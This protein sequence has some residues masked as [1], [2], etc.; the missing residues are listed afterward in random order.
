MPPPLRAVFFDVDDTLYSTAAFA[1]GARRRA[2]EAMVALGGMRISADDLL[3]ELD[4]VIAE[5]GSNYDAHY[6]RLLRRFPP[7]A[8]GGH[9]RGILVAAGVAAYHNTKVE[10]FRAFPGVLDGLRRLRETTGLVLGVITEGLEVKQA[11]KIVRLGIYPWLD[12]RA[13]FISDSIGISKPNPKL[14]QR[15]CACVGIEPARCLY[16]GDNPR[17][18][19]APARS[20]GMWTVRMRSPDGKHAGVA[21]DPPAHH[22]VAD[23]AGLM[24]I[25]QGQYALPPA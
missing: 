2:M 15:A 23:F 24:E 16:V 1:S 10:A 19:I 5:F 17:A 25:L 14:W 4:E 13:I 22:E 6:D 11:E 18:D 12:P 8:L 9:P 20:L 21:A 7:E 3:R